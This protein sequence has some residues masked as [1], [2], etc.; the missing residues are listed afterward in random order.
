M[1]LDGPPMTR[2]EIQELIDKLENGWSVPAGQSDEE[3]EK[4][5]L[6]YKKEHNLP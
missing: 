5:W 1:L 3:V 2:E 6:E 4:A